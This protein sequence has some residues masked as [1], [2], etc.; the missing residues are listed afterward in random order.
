MTVHYAYCYF[1]RHILPNA[2][3]YII[4]F[5]VPIRFL[6]GELNN[7]VHTDVNLIF[8]T[9]ILSGSNHQHKVNF[10]FVCAL[11][12]VFDKSMTLC[13]ALISSRVMNVI[14]KGNIH[15]LY[16]SLWRYNL[17]CV[18]WSRMGFPKKAGIMDLCV[19]PL[20]A[21]KSCVISRLS[22]DSICHDP[23]FT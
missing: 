16:R 8:Y 3:P 23:D 18:S 1:A 6:W 20:L 21:R 17:V 22:A 12:F 11:G 5:K 7:F 2:W 13:N 14:F 15:G 4:L 9:K 10:L 19:S